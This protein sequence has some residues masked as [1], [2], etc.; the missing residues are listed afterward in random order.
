M[1]LHAPDGREAEGGWAHRDGRAQT[2]DRLRQPGWKPGKVVDS[3]LEFSEGNQ[4]KNRS[5]STKVKG[6]D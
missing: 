6:S 3:L 4:N 2:R 5:K 1:L